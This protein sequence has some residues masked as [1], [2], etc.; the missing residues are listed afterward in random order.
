MGDRLLLVTDG[1][2]EAPGKGGHLFGEDGVEEVLNSSNGGDCEAIAD[3]LLSA[4]QHHCGD[5]AL[6]HDDVSFVVIEIVPGPAEPH[7][8]LA[9][10][11]RLMRPRGNAPGPAFVAETANV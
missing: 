8:W 5:T 3:A 6:T 4:L 7:L 2:L 9:I 1:V 10:R 11:N